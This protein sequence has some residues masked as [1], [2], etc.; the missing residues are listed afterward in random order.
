MQTFSQW[1]KPNNLARFMHLITFVI[2]ILF[3]KSCVIY[4]V[5]MCVIVFHIVY[6]IVIDM[7]CSF[8]ADCSHYV[9]TLL[10]F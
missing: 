9:I 7:V 3:S 2:I 5:C 10:D 8:V 4:S 1:L 6:S